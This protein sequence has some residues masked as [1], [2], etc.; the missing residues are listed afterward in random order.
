MLSRGDVGSAALVER[1]AIAALRTI[2]QKQKR[3]STA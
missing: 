1:Q 3:I 2:N